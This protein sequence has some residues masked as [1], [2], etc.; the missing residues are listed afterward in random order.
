MSLKF[1]L[2]SSIWDYNLKP[3]VLVGSNIAIVLLAIVVFYFLFGNVAK[4]ICTKL[5]WLVCLVVVGLACMGV[6]YGL[7][8]KN[9][10]RD[11]QDA[12]VEIVTSVASDNQ[13][14]MMLAEDSDEQLDIEQ[15]ELDE[16][17]GSSEADEDEYYN[18]RNDFLKGWSVMSCVVSMLLFFVL[19]I[20]L[21]WKL[22]PR[23]NYAKSIPFN[24]SK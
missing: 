2:I 15:V 13:G 20:L 1:D 3:V 9:L 18:Q 7:W 10:P 21:N 17:S 19:S 22:L 14:E 5:G 23:G 16:Q 24:L 8:D 6:T 11:Y 4:K 12:N